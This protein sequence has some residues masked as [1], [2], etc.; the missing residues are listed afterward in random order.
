MLRVARLALLIVLPALC[1]LPRAATAQ[2]DNRAWTTYLHAKTCRDVLCTGDTVWLAT[3]EAGLLRY[4]RSSDT[5][6]SITREPNGLAG[7][8]LQCMTFDRRG[9]L[10]VG[11]PGKGVSRLDTDGRWSLINEFDGLPSDT[12]L[13][14]RA[15]GDT[16]W[17]GTTRGLSLWN[18]TTLAGSIP[19]RGIDTVVFANPQINVIAITGDTMIVGTP[20]GA[21]YARKSE[22]LAH[23]TAINGG[24]PINPDVR[25]VATDGRTVTV[26]AAGKNVNGTD[27]LT[28]FTWFPQA[29][30]WGSDFP[31]ANALVRRVRDDFG[32][33]LATTVVSPSVNG[34]IYKRGA[35]GEWNLLTGS[36]RTSNPDDVG[37]EVGK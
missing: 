1:L 30:V 21:Y 15:Q 10:F 5:W 2:F 9:N 26:V 36:P 34:G 25:S 17:I 16:V 8:S 19:D 31:P 32:T 12:A 33:I 14:M 23:W 20:A 6:S 28:S 37:L 13:V 29:G 18:G 22:R 35:P 3:G 11:V 7:N 27:V 4:V 24:L